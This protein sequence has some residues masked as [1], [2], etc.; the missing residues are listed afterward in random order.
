MELLS[1]RCRGAGGRL[2]P[3]LLEQ[4]RASSPSFAHLWKQL[5]NAGTHLDPGL[6]AKLDVNYSLDVLF[7]LTPQ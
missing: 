4:S 3:G 2:V 1:P 5:L 6:T 7:F